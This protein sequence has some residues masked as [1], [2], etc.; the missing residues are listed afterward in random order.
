MGSE[1]GSA[2]ESA[3][4]A[5][6]AGRAADGDVEAFAVLVRR[7]TP[8]MRSYARRILHAGSDADD[9]LQDAFI[10]AWQRL[11]DLDDPAKVKTW[12]MRIV[13]RKSMDAV[14][15]ARSQ[16]D[17]DDAGDAAA[18][19]ERTQPSR[20]AEARAGIDALAAVLQELPDQQRQSWVLRE[21]AGQTYDEIADDMDVSTSTVRGLLARAR[22]QI[23][24]RMKEWR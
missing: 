1:D 2:L 5:I 4:D 8:M 24:V 16:V 14:R 9:V 17:L 3:D 19:P 10:V 20:I 7:Y 23:L 6:L 18:S 22:K 13:G 12:L 21:V 11:P 15:S